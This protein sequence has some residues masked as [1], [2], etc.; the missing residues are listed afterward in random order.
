M[1]NKNSIDL[2]CLFF[3]IGC[4]PLL[5]LVSLP[6]LQL[7]YYCFIVLIIIFI[8][9]LYYNNLKLFSFFFII[10]GL[11]WSTNYAREYLDSITDYID[12]KLTVV[13]EVRSVNIGHKNN[14]L[15]YKKIP[16]NVHFKIIK[17]KQQK[18]PHPLFISLVWNDSRQ[19]FAGEIWRLKIKTKVV[20]SY[21]NEGSFD[22]QR[23]AIANQI[24]LKGNV[25]EAYL[26]NEERNLR[27][28]IVDIA[29]PYIE[30]FNFSDIMLALA[31]G[32]R[33]KLTQDHKTILFQSG[34]AHLLAISG[35]HILLVALLANRSIRIM[36]FFLPI[37]FINYW[38]PMIVGWGF[39]IFYAWLS[40]FNPPAM[41]AILALS[42]WLLFRY[43]HCQLTSWQT[44]NRIIAILL[45]ID[46]L[47]ILSESFWLSCYAVACLIFIAQ[48]FPSFRVNQNNNYFFQLLRLQLLLILLLLPIQLFIFNGTSTMSIIANLIAIPLIS[49]IT[50]PAILFMLITSLLDCFYLSIWFGVIAEQSLNGLFYLIQPLSSFWINAPFTFG[51]LSCIGWLFLIVYKLQLW[52]HFFI[53]LIIIVVGLISPLYKDTGIKWRVDML[54][55][56]HGLAVVISQGKYALL[57]DTG[58]RWQTS[59]AAERIILP[60][61][62][63]HNLNI[64][65]IIISHEHDDHIGGL[66]IIRQN[67]PNAWVMSSSKQ[68]SNNYQ[69]IS[70]NQFQWRE[71]NLLVLWP[72]KMQKQAL[73]P[74]SCVIKVSHKQISILLTGDLERQQEQQL[75]SKYRESLFSTIL[76]IPHHGSN[77]SSFYAFLSHVRPTLSLGS[78]SRYNPWKLP[79]NQVLN[80]YKNLGLTYYLTEEGGQLSVQIY[81]NK[82]LLKTL[83]KQINPRWYHDWFGAL[84]N[85]G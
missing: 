34:I 40:G 5:F 2:A 13:A 12:Q 15:D 25:E 20:H 65:G 7:W 36:Q 55:V 22:N 62:H 44:L 32:E 56:G 29:L 68:L 79:S 64:E 24:L 11:L 23:Y 84:P 76:Q 8:L 54:D 14:H 49:L 67:Y 16:H 47:M 58:A 30:L 26:I 1:G 41:R 31:F 72:E 19:P 42:S 60:F 57:Y 66:N 39:A 59:S 75:V 63:R 35:M 21:L 77:T 4:L 37:R 80:R 48:W 43:F 10:I 74:Q 85:K 82:F 3:S 51:G 69:C 18:L 17:I 45:L 83:R 78:V 50:F 81:S 53:S 27:Q 70:G 71:L 28:K 38:H 61:L 33:S 73:N 6:T 9:Y 46:P 52:R